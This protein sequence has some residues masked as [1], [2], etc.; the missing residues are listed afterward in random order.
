LFNAIFNRKSCDINY[1]ALGGFVS[2]A[3][4]P[5]VAMVPFYL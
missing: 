4:H 5:M 1:N 2:T 3:G